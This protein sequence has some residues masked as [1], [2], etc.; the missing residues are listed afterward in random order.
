MVP[1]RNIQFIK[2][3]LA[4][5]D[6]PIV[7]Q[8]LGGDKPL[9]VHFFTH[10]GQVLVKLLGRSHIG[11]ITQDTQRYQAE[12]IKQMRH[13]KHGDITLFS[14]PRKAKGKHAHD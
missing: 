1:E 14:H 8:H 3:F 5:E 13:P 7:G 9:L 11:Q 4:T 10:T 2:E 12:V 6:I